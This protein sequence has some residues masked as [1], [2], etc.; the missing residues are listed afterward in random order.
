MLRR[1]KTEWLRE[2][3]GKGDWALA[4]SIAN[5]FQSRIREPHRDTIRLAHECRVHPAFYRAVGRDPELAVE[6]GIASLRALFDHKR[7]VGQ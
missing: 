2:A 1:T 7:E 4:L 3:M 5:T 6:A